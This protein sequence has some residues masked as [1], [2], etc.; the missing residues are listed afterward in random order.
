MF[1]CEFAFSLGLSLFTWV[2]L[3]VLSSCFKLEFGIFPFL[4]HLLILSPNFRSGPERSF[5]SLSSKLHPSF[6]IKPSYCL[7]ISIEHLLYSNFWLFEASILTLWISEWVLSKIAKIDLVIG[8]NCQN[9]DFSSPSSIFLC[10]NFTIVPYRQ[11]GVPSPS[12]QSFDIF[13]KLFWTLSLTLG[14]LPLNL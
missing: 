6:H 4:S 5:F 12:T 11:I 3:W 2:F 13:F 8:P 7:F 14:T 1:K 10:L 9:W